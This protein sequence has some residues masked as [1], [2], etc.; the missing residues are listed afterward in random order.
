MGWFDDTLGNVGG[1]I[2]GSALGSLLTNKANKDIAK[3]N[4]AFQERMSSTSYQRS[5]ADMKKA[6]LNPMLAYMKG[7][8]ST[9]AGAMAH[10]ENPAKDIP[11]SAMAN[12]LQRKQIEAID[13]T[14]DQTKSNTSLNHQ[15]AS[16][17]AA[18]ATGSSGVA[19]LIKSGIEGFENFGEWI[20]TSA[21]KVMQSINK[22]KGS[23]TRYDW[24]AHKK[25]YR[26]SQK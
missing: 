1:S 6:G 14:I 12:R 9:P 18:M 11:A 22:M 10:M 7:G 15:K 13:A 4:R 24:E 17:L 5:M 16:A 25:Y 23:P 26:Q 2:A 20:G 21:A 3:S 8:A 19:P